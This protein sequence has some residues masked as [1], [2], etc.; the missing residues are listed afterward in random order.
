MKIPKRKTRKPLWLIKQ[1]RLGEFVTLSHQLKMTFAK[2]GV[3][4]AEL[5]QNLE[6]FN[7]VLG[8][9]YKEKIDIEVK[10]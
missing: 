9:Y 10:E 6:K 1:K 3:S 8:C 2:V 5:S 7:E 4:A